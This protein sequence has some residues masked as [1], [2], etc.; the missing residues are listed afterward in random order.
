[1]QCPDYLKVRGFG[2]EKTQKWVIYLNVTAHQTT[3]QRDAGTGGWGLQGFALTAEG[4]DIHT[5]TVPCL[6]KVWLVSSRISH[7]SII[8]LSIARFFR[9]FSVS[10]TSSC[11][12][13]KERE[14]KIGAWMRFALLP[15]DPFGHM[16][17]AA[18]HKTKP[19]GI[20]RE[21]QQSSVPIQTWELRR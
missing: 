1:M 6:T 13:L 5:N 16:A 19:K 20:S 3:P 10:L 8:I 4:R 11:I 7:P 17:G 12:I 2:A 18:L 14:E 9:I 15:A 21:L